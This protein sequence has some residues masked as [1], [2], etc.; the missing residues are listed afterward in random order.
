[1]KRWLIL[2]ASVLMVLGLV[3]MAACAPAAPPTEEKPYAG[4][5]VHAQMWGGP[6]G[7]AIQKCIV[8]PWEEETGAKLAVEI[9]GTSDSIAK[10]M[11]QKADPLLDI[12]YMDGRGAAELGVEGLLEVLDTKKIPNMAEI[13][14][15]FIVPGGYGVGFAIAETGLAYQPDLVEEPV[16]SLEILFD[17]QYA[18]KVVLPTF[19]GSEMHIL[20][21][22]LA[23]MSGGS[24][25]D[26]EPGLAKFAELKPQVLTQTGDV[27]TVMELMKEGDA[28]F[29]YTY[30]TVLQ[31]Y[32]AKGYP[33]VIVP[34]GDLKE[35]TYAEI[36]CNAIVK[37]HK[38]PAELVEA[39]VNRAMSRE[40]QACLAGEL[41]L[42]VPN[43]YAELE[44]ELADKVVNG[45]EELARVKLM[46][47]DYWREVREEWTEGMH[48]IWGE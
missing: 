36:M 28:A 25:Y 34:G 22:K 16:D 6:E 3:V 29:H 8:Q 1:M 4:V 48:E 18:G 20:L 35:G 33:V 47:Y 43:R 23:E 45:D 19:E 30:T 21:V 31:A 13:H 9:G 41:L 10:V 37:G 39:L 12:T 2:A 38:A 14:P 44:S 40:A 27:A 15:N 42:G 5:T 32:V 26:I 24:I 7:A 11:A 46:P 17:P